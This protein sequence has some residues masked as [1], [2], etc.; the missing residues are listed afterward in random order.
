MVFRLSLSVGA[1]DQL[2]L[3]LKGIVYK[4]LLIKALNRSSSGSR[5]V[6]QLLLIIINVWHIAI[7]YTNL[8]I[9]NNM[10]IIVLFSLNIIMFNHY[11]CFSP[12]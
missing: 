12:P 6:L 9:I 2:S 10:Q 5:L 8:N 11:C 7:T 3:C 1:I 4:L